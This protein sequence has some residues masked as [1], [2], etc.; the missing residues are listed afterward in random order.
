MSHQQASMIWR[1]H[2][3]S[4]D[5]QRVFTAD[6]FLLMRDCFSEGEIRRLRDCADAGNTDSRECGVALSNTQC[7]SPFDAQFSQL[8]DVAIL[9]ERIGTIVEA[10][11]RSSVKFVDSKMIDE[12]EVKVGGSW[13]WHQDYWYSYQHG[14]LFP[15]MANCF[16]ALHESSSRNDNLQVIRGSHRLG[17]IDHVLL[18]ETGLRR[19]V[20][21]EISSVARGVDPVWIG[22]DPDRVDA[23][24]KH[25]ETVNINMNAGDLFVMH[26]NCLHRSGEPTASQHA[27]ALLCT[28]YS[29]VWNEAIGHKDC[30]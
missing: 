13:P 20:L 4:A 30:N 25:L 17:R 18:T 14:F 8:P 28:C 6:G 15:D 27:P 23:A 26:G 12:R 7:I 10:L 11:I 9:L 21:G 24:Q 19:E 2:Q 5:Q 29:A 3:I 22:A 16:I 1:N